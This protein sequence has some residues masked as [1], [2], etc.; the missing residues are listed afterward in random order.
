M[1]KPWQD[2]SVLIAGCGSIG[3]RHARVLHGLGVREIGACDPVEPQ[4]ESLQSEVSSVTLYDSYESCLRDRPDTVF[5]CTPPDLHISMM[6]LALHAGCHVMCEKP[7]SNSVEGIDGLDALAAEKNRK[8]MVAL[9]FRYHEGLVKAKHYLEEGR[10]GRLVAVRALMGEHLP[11]VRPD[12]RNLFS[13]RY[14]GAFDLTHEVDLA[15]WYAGQPVRRVQSL[16]GTYSDI[17]IEAPDVAQILIEFEDRCLAN[18]HLDFF[19]KP[20]RRQMELIGTDGVILVEF[21]RWDRCTL[22]RYDAAEGDW[23]QEELITDR[24]DMFRAED[25]EFLQAVAAD[26]P[27]TCTIAEAKRSVEVIAAARPKPSQAV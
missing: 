15:V 12:Y 25:L 13:A 18:I 23:K 7:L 9:C 6:E 16:S 17:G 3:R 4:R 26:K 21:A 2:L 11:D 24:D 8:V 20:R 22:S 10:I 14:D 27:V 5:I 19:Q 1:K